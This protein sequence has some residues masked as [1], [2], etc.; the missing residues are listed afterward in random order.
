MTA[1]L[2]GREQLE[3]GSHRRVWKR[4]EERERERASAGDTDHK[5]GEQPA[6]RVGN[7][8]VWLGWGST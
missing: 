1:S 6:W 2:R 3:E 5:R 8:G 7:G 4:E